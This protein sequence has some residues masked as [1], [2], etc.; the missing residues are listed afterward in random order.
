[1]VAR[2][3]PGDVP[4]VRQAMEAAM[5]TNPIVNILAAQHPEGY[6]TKPGPGYGPKY[7]GAVWSR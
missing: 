1:M 4:E 5:A 6:W 7:R 2:D 3:L